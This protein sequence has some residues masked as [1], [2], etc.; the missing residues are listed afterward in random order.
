MAS[1][2]VSISRVLDSSLAVF[3][4]YGFQKTTMQ[5]IATAAGMSRAALYLHFKNKEDVFRS[6]SIRAHSQVMDEVAAQLAGPGSVMD[7]VEAA[8][9]AYFA[10]LMEEITASPHGPE[11]FDATTELVG[12][13]ARQARVNLI[14][15]IAAQLNQADEDG[16][17]D[18][19][20]VT[21][22]SDELAGFL[23]AAIDGLKHQQVSALPVTSGIALQMRL[24]RLSVAA[25][26]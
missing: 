9:V 6:G 13:L 16:E 20:R 15:L 4:R 8:L 17:I 22:S 24:A 3:C 18:L 23:V 2:E 12:D 26:L 19:A 1:S 7:R 14:Q 10:G 25:E 5:D 11:L 21:V